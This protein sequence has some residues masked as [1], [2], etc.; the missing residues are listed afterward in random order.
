[1]I[2]LRFLTH[3]SCL[4]IFQSVFMLFIPITHFTS[5]WLSSRCVVHLI[6]W[7]R[8]TSLKWRNF[9]SSSNC[10]L[11]YEILFG[12][13][14]FEWLLYGVLPLIRSLP[15][16]KRRLYRHAFYSLS[17]EL[18][19]MN[20]YKNHVF[21]TMLTS[22]SFKASIFAKAISSIQSS[23]IIFVLPIEFL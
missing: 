12:T 8:H 22:S 10:K 3:Y 17:Q 4:H 14:F 21:L 15:S 13:F 7:H 23:L 19:Q 5:A 16:H 2:S 6:L 9:F 20:P 11:P 1:M 18:T